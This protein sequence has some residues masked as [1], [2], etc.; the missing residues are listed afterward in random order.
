[1]G[2]FIKTRQDSD[3]VKINH[4]LQ[5]S[6]PEC[7]E[8]PNRFRFPAQAMFLINSFLAFVIV[9]ANKVV[10]SVAIVAM[11]TEI[12][13]NSTSAI[14]HPLTNTIN[15]TNLTFNMTAVPPLLNPNDPVST[16]DDI[17]TSTYAPMWSAPPQETLHVPP[18]P[19]SKY[20]KSRILGAFFTGYIVSQVPAGR[21]AE[22]FGA[23][24]LLGVSLLICSLISFLMPAAALNESIWLAQ[25][26]DSSRW[27]AFYAKLYHMLGPA[28]GVQV[29]RSMQG[30]CTGV[31]HPCMHALIT[32]WTPRTQRSMTT[33][34]IYSG[35]QIGTVFI[36]P[37][38]GYL[39]S[40]T[41]MGNLIH[42]PFTFSS[43]TNVN[44]LYQQVA[45]RPST[46]CSVCSE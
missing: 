16:A 7:S 14:H 18:I 24:W 26:P 37:V 25:S 30:L 40:G 32:R 2:K 36:M 31:A 1:M 12:N 34:F 39:A 23:K 46:I 42:F 43:L 5:H 20:T 38:T 17:V 21:L 45:G 3:Q 35:S 6:S 33:A 4:M 9:Y 22:R 10:L 27:S 41:I 15:T 11:Y 28:A 19:V 8:R 29:L 44:C 13:D